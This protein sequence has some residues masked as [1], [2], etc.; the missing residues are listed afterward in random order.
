MNKVFLL[1]FV[2]LI[3]L[4]TFSFTQLKNEPNL[5][6]NL[7]AGGVDFCPKPQYRSDKWMNTFLA[8]IQSQ[9][10]DST[11]LQF[12]QD[13]IPTD[14]HV[15]ST[16]QILS[17][18]SQITFDSSRIQALTLLNPYIISLTPQNI[19][20]ILIKYPFESS[21]LT[22]LNLIANTLSDVSDASKKL[23]VDCFTFDSN[24]SDAL[25]ILNAISP[26]NCIYGTITEKVAAFV[27][28]ISGSMEYTFKANGETISRLAFVKSQLTKTIAEQLK[29]Y[30]KFNI[31]IFGNS[32]SQWKTD[33]VDASPENVQAA[34]AY[35]NKLT[36]NGA[37]NISSGLDLAFNTKQALK[38][39]YLLSDGVPNSGVQTVDGIKKYLTE[40]NASRT[41]KVV[42]NTISF[43]MGGVEKQNERDLSFQFLNT[44]ADVTNGSFK[45]ISG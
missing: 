4:P 45:G 6:A 20:N 21:K 2:T 13:Q 33:Y 40:K 7:E 35:I 17:I 16:E 41:E 24:K 27:I 22:A 14:S 11:M 43:I 32:A 28:D 8:G 42:V 3:G 23:I 19:V 44:I 31:I 9:K 25:K 30:Q 37:T 1:A 26:R 18:F 12:L 5:R 15:F 29:S 38:A 10:Y 39:I 36:T 34:I